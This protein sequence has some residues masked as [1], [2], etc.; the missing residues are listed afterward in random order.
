[1]PPYLMLLHMIILT[2]LSRSS[3]GVTYKDVNSNWK[4]QIFA[5]IQ[6]K[7]NFNKSS[8]IVTG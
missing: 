4:L 5:S 1:M 2:I 6:A 8:K 7:T 3:S